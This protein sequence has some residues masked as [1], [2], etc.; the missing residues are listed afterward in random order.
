MQSGSMQL[1]KLK[2]ENGQD[3]E[4]IMLPSMELQLQPQNMP[5]QW[6]SLKGKWA[7]QNTQGVTAHILLGANQATRFPQA[8]K[9]ASGAL[10]QVNQARL[11]KSEITGKNIMFGCSNPPT[12]TEASDLMKPGNF[13]SPRLGCKASPTLVSVITR[14]IGNLQPQ[15]DTK[16]SKSP[17]VKRKKDKL[18]KKLRGNPNEI[19]LSSLR[20]SKERGTTSKRLDTIQPFPQQS[21]YPINQR[22]MNYNNQQ[23][24]QK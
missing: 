6:K 4:A 12:S 18:K 3:I 11:M 8:V 1:C 14:I 24:S 5:N 10:L 20:E 19:R 16:Q 22:E 13:K 2:L 23:L 9:D 17:I 15:G 21:L 7:N